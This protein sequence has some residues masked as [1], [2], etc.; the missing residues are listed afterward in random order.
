MD[1]LDNLGTREAEQL[2]VALQR[3][4]MVC[5][6]RAAV[7]GF[8]QLVLL[9]HRAHGPVQNQDAFR[10]GVL[11]GMRRMAEGSRGVH[12]AA[13]FPLRGEDE[14]RTDETGPDGIFYV[15]GWRGVE[16]RGVS[17]SCRNISVTSSDGLHGPRRL[18]RHIP[19]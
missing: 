1:L 9:H 8:L 16:R 15:Q 18:I 5:Q 11:D 10:Q 17:G 14:G 13:A 4:V 7:I 3:P 19:T 12:R 6:Q 2:G